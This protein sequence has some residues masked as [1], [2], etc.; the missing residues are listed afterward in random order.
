LYI[1]YSGT[2]KLLENIKSK[3]NLIFQGVSQK[4]LKNILNFFQSYFKS[5]LKITFFTGS[6]LQAKASEYQ[7]ESSS[8]VCGE[9]LSE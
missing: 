8:L 5:S 2:E 9:N 1:V 6:I 7:K 3:R 4:Y